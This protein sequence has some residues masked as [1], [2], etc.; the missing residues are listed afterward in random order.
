[1]VKERVRV[2]HYGTGKADKSPVIIE[3]PAKIAEA[4]AR[5]VAP[6]SFA[7]AFIDAYEHVATASEYQ[8]LGEDVD[9]LMRA[10]KRGDL[11]FEKYFGEVIRIWRKRDWIGYNEVGDTR[12]REERTFDRLGRLAAFAEFDYTVAECRV[13]W[14]TWFEERRTFTWRRASIDGAVGIAAVGATA[15]TF[16]STGDPA[17]LMILGAGL[18]LRFRTHVYHVIEPTYLRF[19][20]YH[21]LDALPEEREEL[22]RRMLAGASHLDVIQFVAEAVQRSEE[23]Q[24]VAAL[25]VE[26]EEALFRTERELEAAEASLPPQASAFGAILG[27]PD[28]DSP[29][30]EHVEAQRALLAELRTRAEELKAH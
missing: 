24:A 29:E 12:T 1:M 26:I 18:F 17:S 20:A 4:G 6:Y 13:G 14:I 10:F 15:A 28:S 5:I 8:K 16:A 11:D 27:A 7:L 3:F 19:W 23:K 25:S 30:R 2:S 9:W 21:E 22:Y